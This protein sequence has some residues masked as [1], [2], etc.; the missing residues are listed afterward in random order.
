MLVIL[1]HLFPQKMMNYLWTP[2]PRSYKSTIKI[3]IIHHSHYQYR[4]RNTSL[5]HK[6]I[7]SCYRRIFKQGKW[8]VTLFYLKNAK[9]EQFESRNATSMVSYCSWLNAIADMK[10]SEFGIHTA[11]H[12]VRV[13]VDA[14]YAL[15]QA[16]KRAFFSSICVNFVLELCSS[17]G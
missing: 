6:F 17:V 15:Q 1:I 13:R 14:P 5:F 2:R 8:F 12:S 10:P 7:I 16:M 9:I 11:N 3:A 4:N